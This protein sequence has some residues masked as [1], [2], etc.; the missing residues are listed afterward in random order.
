MYVDIIIVRQ[1]S[2]LL[3]LNARETL[4]KGVLI[5]CKKGRARKNGREKN[6]TISMCRGE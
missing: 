5:L 4:Y 1:L 3:A 2:M 6:K